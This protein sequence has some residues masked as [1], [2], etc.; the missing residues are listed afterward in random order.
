MR[1]KNFFLLALM[2]VVLSA[3]G[4]PASNESKNSEEQSEPM[5]SAAVEVEADARPMVKVGG[6]VYGDTGY[7]NAMVTC[8]T[9]DGKI[10][11]T[12]EENK[13][14]V[15]DDESNFG[16]GYNYQIWEKGYINVQTDNGWTLFRDIDLKEENNQIPKWVA[17]FTAKVSRVE[18][19]SLMVEASEIDDA[20][21]FKDLLTKPISLPMNHLENGGGGE[22]A[23]QALEGKSVEVYFGGEI[24]NTQPESSVP[25]SL[26]EVYRISVK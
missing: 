7:K 14:P 12:V 15:N 17:H 20:F 8:G 2:I 18:D 9:P 22:P 6:V 25:I 5:E 11:S 10:N 21:Y 26:E 1:K 24:K 13:I 4:G 3:C 19:D 16:K 23:G